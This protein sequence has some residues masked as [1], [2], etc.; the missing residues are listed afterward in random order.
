MTR[1]RSSYCRR[2]IEGLLKGKI[3]G[4]GK[5][6]TAEA[7]VQTEKPGT[8]DDPIRPPPTPP[9]T[10][11]LRSPS[12]APQPMVKTE[13]SG[14]GKFKECFQSRVGWMAVEGGRTESFEEKRLR[15]YG[16]IYTVDR[17]GAKKE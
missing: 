12:P 16:Y 5:G 2:C 9:H 14:R 3:E 6:K 7:A 17:P 8:P 4:K 1:R 11:T 13:G 15:D 10:R